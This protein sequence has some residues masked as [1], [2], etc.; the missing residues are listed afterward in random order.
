MQ[1]H[2]WV[3]I[4]Y[5]GCMLPATVSPCPADSVWAVQCSCLS[6]EPHCVSLPHSPS[7]LLLWS[8]AQCRFSG[9]HSAGSAVEDTHVKLLVLQTLIYID[10]L[11]VMLTWLCFSVT[12]LCCSASCRSPFSLSLNLTRS[13]PCLWLWC[14]LLWLAS[15]SKPRE[16]RE[17][18]TPTSSLCS[19]AIVKD[20][21]VPS[22]V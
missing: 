6:P 7:V 8:E 9:G 12:S 13:S 22:G 1:I 21:V 17:L 11:T 19:W 20:S 14:R 2:I 3:R 18:W 16:N 15:S 4:D 5:M 10:K